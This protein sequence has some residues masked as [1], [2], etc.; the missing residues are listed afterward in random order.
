MKKCKKKFD[1]CY[2]KSKQI[3]YEYIWWV[4]FQQNKQNTKAPYIKLKTYK[5]KHKVIKIDVKKN[6]YLNVLVYSP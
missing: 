3:I 6:V 4:L 2:Y 5:W 1:E